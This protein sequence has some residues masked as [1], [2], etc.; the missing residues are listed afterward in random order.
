MFAVL[1]YHKITCYSDV[2]IMSTDEIG[3]EENRTILT[4]WSM[5]KPLFLFIHKS[6][7]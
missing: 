2:S 1:K 5:L 3:G 7:F 6:G 4:L